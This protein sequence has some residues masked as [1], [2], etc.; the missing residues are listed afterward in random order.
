MSGQ[1]LVT[2]GSGKTGR[3]IIETLENAGVPYR[4]AARSGAG[5]TV[6]HFDWTDRSTWEAALDG[7]AAVYLLSPTMSEDP[8]PLLI[9]FVK[10]AM[11]QGIRRFVLQSASLLPAGGPAMGKVHQWLAD[12]APQWAVLRPSWFMQNFSEGAH[13]RTIRAE[14]KIYSAAGDGPVPFIHVGD[15][16][17]SAFAMLTAKRAANTDFILTGVDLLTYDDVAQKI[18]AATG[19]SVVH[20]RLT[21][22]QLAAAHQNAGLN[23][24]AAHAL[25]AMDHAIAKCAENRIT[26]CVK[27]LTRQDPVCFQA[28]VNEAASAWR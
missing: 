18:S 21:P 7:T 17:R 20:V 8:A 26:T 14:G 2:G 3:R 5:P 6:V 15:I 24:I 1:I 19:R 9:D 11:S 25:A 13:V 16:A 12:N 28:F 10:K 4:A 23:S 22:A 27:D